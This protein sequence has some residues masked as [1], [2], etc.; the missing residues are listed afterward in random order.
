VD[1]EGGKELILR[2]NKVA[3]FNKDG[4]LIYSGSTSS[5]GNAVKYACAAIARDYAGGKP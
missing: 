5:L 1:H 3:V 4:D 2:D